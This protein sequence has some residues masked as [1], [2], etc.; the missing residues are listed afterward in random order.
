MFILILKI[1]LLYYNDP[2]RFGFVK[3]IKG[4]IS[5]KNYFKNMGLIHL[6]VIL[7]LVMLKVIFQKTK[8]TK[9]ILLDQKNLFQELAIYMQVKY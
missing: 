1:F 5:L 2:R 7:I 9:N 3:L 6:I 8:N 4:K